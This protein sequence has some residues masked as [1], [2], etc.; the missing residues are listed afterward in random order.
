MKN[1]QKSFD[2]ALNEH[3]KLNLKINGHLPDWLRGQYVI[4][5]PAR[6]MKFPRIFNHWFDKFGVLCKFSFG[7][8]GVSFSNKYIRSQQYIH[9]MEH[10][11]LYFSEFATSS[12]RNLWQRLLALTRGEMDISDNVNVN[13]IKIDHILVAISDIEKMIKFDLS[14]LDTLDEFLFEDK[15]LGWITSAH[16]HI[17]AHN[18]TIID[19]LIN[20]YPKIIYTICAIKPGSKIRSVIATYEPQQLFYM[21]SFSIT[22]HYVILLE[23]P[24]KL[25]T[26]NYFLSQYLLNKPPIE[27]LKEQSSD[28]AFLVVIEKSTGKIKRI[29]TA[30]FY[31]SHTVNAYEKQDKIILDVITYNKALYYQDLLYKNLLSDD[32]IASSSQLSRFIININKYSVNVESFDL[33]NP[34][35]PR[36]N[37]AKNNSNYYRYMYSL[38]REQTKNIKLSLVKY[39][40]EKLSANKWYQNKCYPGEPLFVASSKEDDDDGVVL[41]VV[42]NAEINK[43]FLLV[44]D[45]KSF[46]EQA[47]I[48]LPF[49]LPALLH[50]NFYN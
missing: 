40:V 30:G 25:K 2:I 24:L 23:T 44:L 47:R 11:K 12:S 28:Q 35:F 21:H 31:F 13:T 33:P 17:D 50:S 8:N 36:I 15:L 19:V 38:S 37:Y 9:A 22:E 48:D 4:I 29:P 16:P 1:Y 20:S 42:F 18:G 32:Y 46:Q 5:G 6:P 14:S 7:D 27:L 10:K 3:E 39:D 41:S 43:S 45:A 49:G 26:K 34:E